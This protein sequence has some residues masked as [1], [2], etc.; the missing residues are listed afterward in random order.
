MS[1]RFETAIQTQTIYVITNKTARVR[2]YH[3]R[4]AISLQIFAEPVYI[5]RCVQEFDV[6]A[7]VVF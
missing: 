1:V 3:H 5:Q 7:R 2:R 4:L 6:L